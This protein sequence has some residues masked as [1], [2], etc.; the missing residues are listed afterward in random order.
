VLAADL[1]CK[2]AARP[3]ALNREP[4]AAFVLEDMGGVGLDRARCG[5]L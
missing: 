5:I 1:H 4:R 3:V 2:C